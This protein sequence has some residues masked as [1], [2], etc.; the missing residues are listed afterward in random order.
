MRIQIGDFILYKYM[1]YMNK[2][3]DYTNYIIV[4]IVNIFDNT[5]Y[6]A[7]VDL[8]V[9]DSMSITVRRLSFNGVINSLDYKL[10]Y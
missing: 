7:E 1:D 5:K 8:L 4:K 3:G 9:I 10:Y 6:V 2:S